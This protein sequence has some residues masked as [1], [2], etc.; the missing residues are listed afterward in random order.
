LTLVPPNSA[1]SE[2]LGIVYNTFT[3]IFLIAGGALL[4]G[5]R[6]DIDVRTLARV[7]IYLFVP[8]LILAYCSFLP[9]LERDKTCGENSPKAVIPFGFVFGQ[10]QLS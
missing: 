5:R 1:V 9:N 7:N 10:Y 2:F 3:P 6:F 8:S 4:V